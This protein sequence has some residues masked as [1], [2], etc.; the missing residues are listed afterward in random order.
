MDFDDIP[1]KGKYNWKESNLLLF[2]TDSEK[3]VKKENAEAEPMWQGSGAKPGLEIWRINKFKVEKW[4]KDDYGKFYS[5]DSY[6]VM[7]TWKAEGSEALN[8]DIHFWIGKYSTQDEYATAAYKTVELDTFHS[9]KPI[10]HREVQGNESE[11]FKGYFD[12]YTVMKGGCDTGFRRVG[13]TGY[14]PRLFQVVGE[15]KQIAITQVPLKRGNLNSEDVFILDMG[16]RIFQFN[17]ETATKDEKFKATQYVNQMRSERQGKPRLDIL[18]ERSISPGHRFYKAIPEGKSK[19]K[20][21]ETIE[22][23]PAMYK[24]AEEFGNVDFKPVLTGSLDRNELNSGDVM[25]CV[26]GKELYAW[27]GKGASIDERKN[28]MTYIHRY[29]YKENNPYL[30]VTVIS[31]GQ[32]CPEFDAIF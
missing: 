26:T 6:I 1:Q 13:P 24:I 12:F 8:H 10:Q 30:P 20:T 15:K 22:L 18:E 25:I 4:P 11:K 23:E 32:K 19:E 28:T 9:D 14:K 7:N 16:L 27:I 3:K 29:L 31:E 5:G 17:G 21:D 2:G